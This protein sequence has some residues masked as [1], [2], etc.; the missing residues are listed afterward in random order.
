MKKLTS[1]GPFRSYPDWAPRD[2]VEIHISRSAKQTHR[3]KIEE[4]INQWA[5]ER[6]MSAE[7]TASLREHLYRTQVLLFED[8]AIELLGKLLTDSRMEEVWAS[9]GRRSQDGYGG[10]HLWLVCNGTLAAWRSE[11]KLTAKERER[12]FLEIHDLALKLLSAMTRTK[13]FTHYSFGNQINDQR[14]GGK[15]NQIRTS[16]PSKNE[17]HIDDIWACF[18]GV[19]P[20][21]HTLLLEIAEKAKDYSQSVDPL[22]KKPSSR[23]AEIH[24]FVRSLSGHFRDRYG[25]PLHD[26]VAIIAN[27]V[28]S[29]DDLDAD[30]VRK[31]VRT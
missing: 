15:L 17:E 10:I 1:G 9:I 4:K 31:L 23:N 16:P 7:A 11:P 2:L 14:I 8:E 18:S 29:R 21:F 12:H 22:V 3:P 6:Q 13:E 25:Q 24:Y 5:E 19:I 26:A 27:V 30:L 28:F 20:A